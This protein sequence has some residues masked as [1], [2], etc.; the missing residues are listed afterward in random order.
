[1]CYVLVMKTIPL[2]RGKVALVDDE[3]FQRISQHC[4]YAMKNRRA[5]GTWY[6]A[7]N[8]SIKDGPRYK[9]L[10]HREILGLSNPKVRP[11]HRDNDGLNNQKYN[12][13]IA[14]HQQNQWNQKKKKINAA[15]PYRGVCLHKQRGKWYARIRINGK[16]TSLG[17]FASEI[18][19]A[20]AYNAAALKHHGPFASLNP[21]SS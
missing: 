1:M 17:L 15:S 19:A 8:S 16:D 2:T 14:T 11:D 9:I 7:R 12:L 10:M 4:W 13:R 6:A 20:R 21:I 18:E 3:D 5:V